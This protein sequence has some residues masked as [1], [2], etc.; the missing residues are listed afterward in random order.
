MK[1][2]KYLFEE[3]INEIKEMYLKDGDSAF[4]KEDGWCLYVCQ[5]HQNK[6]RF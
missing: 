2:T 5:K 1:K 6:I 3:V 4:Y